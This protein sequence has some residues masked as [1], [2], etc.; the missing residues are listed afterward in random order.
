MALIMSIFLPALFAQDYSKLDPFMA[1]MV[2]DKAF[3]GTVLFAKGDSIVYHK[4]FGPAI[5]SGTA[6]N[7]IESQYLI[8]SITKT[9]TAVG[10][11]Q[12]YEEGKLS[13]SDPLS[14]YISLF[15]NGEKVSIRDLL[16][17]RSGIKNYT[18]LP[19]LMAW[20][21]EEIKPFS[22][23]DKVMDYP[24]AFEPGSMHMYSN[25]NYLLLG[26][27]LEQVSGM[28]YEKYVTS[29]ILKP[30]G[31]NHTGI[32]R[33]KAKQLSEGLS[34]EDQNWVQADYVDPSVPFSAG[35]LYST[36][37]DLY[38]FSK[39]FF[40]AEFFRD[41]ASYELMTNFDEGFY[42]LGIY[43]EQIDEQVYIGHNGG[44]D[45][46]SSAWY[47]FIDLDLHVIILS[48]SFDSK[49]DQV[50]DA[51]IHVH[52]EKEIEIPQPKIAISLP[53]KELEQF[54][55]A[56]QIQRGFDLNIFLDRNSIYAQASGQDAFEIFA[57]SDS[58][59]FAKATDI[60]IIFQKNQSGRAQALTLYQG[61]GQT[62]APRKTEEVKAI[63]LTL[64]E[65]EVLEGIYE[66]QAGFD[67][68]VFVENEKLYGQAT[69]QEAFELIPESR[70]DFFTNGL[71]IEVSFIFDENGETNKLSLFQGGGKID[72]RKKGQ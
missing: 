35:N 68:K 71:G 21:G 44:I 60:E 50:A 49:I 25:T 22:L 62:V 2:E 11:M 3:T 70:K 9:F 14:K 51:V 16:T 43:A 33:K 36:T 64:A 31:M 65:L 41:K 29:K 8:G 24:L 58:S 4:G 40:N 30:A 6:P 56:Y 39:A 66:L 1:K 37:G 15:P 38:S 47:Y 61:G 32:N 53:I 13:L 26:I 45:G 5:L 52:L 20:K 19:D 59:F 46:Y 42:A 72:A 18:E 48:N 28:E 69:G 27:I 63:E 34:V 17:H 55:G 67:L 7:S 23:L 10:I 54:V 12:L 57:D